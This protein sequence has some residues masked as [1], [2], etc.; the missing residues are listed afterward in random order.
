[1]KQ[2]VWNETVDTC[3]CDHTLHHLPIITDI[4]IHTFKSN[5]ICCSVMAMALS[6]HT[7]I[8]VYIFRRHSVHRFRML[9]S[10]QYSS[11]NDCIKNCL[12]EFLVSVFF[13]KLF[14]SQFYD[15]ICQYSI[16]IMCSNVCNNQTFK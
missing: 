14:A 4:H 3:R 13:N 6:S 8:F 7:V 1:M 5:G 16:G 11:V 9:T 2:F 10:S 12:C 15:K